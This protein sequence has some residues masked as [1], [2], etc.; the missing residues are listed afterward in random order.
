MAAVGQRVVS[1]LAS[2]LVGRQGL[3][4]GSV[5]RAS[6]ER[7]L[8][9][10]LRVLRGVRA[11]LRASFLRAA[12][13]D[14]SQL[15]SGKKPLAQH[16]GILTPPSGSLLLPASVEDN[17]ISHLHSTKSSLAVITPCRCCSIILTRPGALGA[18][19]KISSTAWDKWTPHQTHLS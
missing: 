3:R 7:L 15:L 2:G 5:D 4:A 17:Q 10:A 6:H 8:E 9:V 18:Q 13:P 11:V 12:C 19:L 14:A 1:V 16:F